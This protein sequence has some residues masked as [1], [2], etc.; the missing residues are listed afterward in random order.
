[1]KS[2]VLDTSGNTIRLMF[3]DFSSALNTIQ[4]HL[5]DQKLLKDE[6]SSVVP[7]VF[8]CLTNR[9]FFVSLK[10][11]RSA[12]MCTNTVDHSVQYLLHSSSLC[13]QLTAGIL[14]VHAQ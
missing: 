8:N 2:C 6:S 5:M 11:T 14:T 4:P 12:V 3:F 7:R 1:M 10:G 9:P 13:K